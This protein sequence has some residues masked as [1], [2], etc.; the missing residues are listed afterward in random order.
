[1]SETNLQMWRRLG[2]VGKD[3]LKKAKPQ[4]KPSKHRKQVDYP[5]MLLFDIIALGW[6]EPAREHYFHPIRKW[7]LDLAWVD[8]KLGVEC[9]GGVY[10]QGRHTRG[11][12]YI[13]DREKMNSAAELGW[14][15]IEVCCPMD[16]GKAI[17]WIETA[18][19]NKGVI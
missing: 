16:L 7:R 17:D 6:P 5:G 8:I 13:K 4:R 2:L 9:H 1:M 19:R 14:Q 12:G 10:S 3:G 11:S 18:L 15:V